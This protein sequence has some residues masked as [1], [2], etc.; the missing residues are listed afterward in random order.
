MD[1]TYFLKTKLQENQLQEAVKTDELY[2]DIDNQYLKQL[3]AIMHQRFNIL[4]M[5]MR[6]KKQSNGH[7][8][9]AESRE[10]LGLI[11]LYEDMLYVLKTTPLSFRL[12]ESYDSM[13]SFCK[14]FLQESN[15]SA[16]PDNLPDFHI[17]E[18]DPI[19]YMSQ[20]ISVP[21]VRK[22]SKF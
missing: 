13:L 16:I 19:F 4:I 3:F 2:I 18:Y 11:K 17:I 20:I 15:G 7:F 22:D 10:L 8:N 14:G 12:E 5:F 9:A 6:T 1:I 21:D